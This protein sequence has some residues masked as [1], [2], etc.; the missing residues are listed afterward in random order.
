MTMTEGIYFTS[1]DPDYIFGEGVRVAPN[2]GNF[3]TDAT[4][5][6]ETDTHFLEF[7]IEP[8]NETET[9]YVIAL[10]DSL[11]PLPRATDDII[12]EGDILKKNQHFTLVSHGSNMATQSFKAMRIL[13]N[14][15]KLLVPS[16][17]ERA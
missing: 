9:E 1:P 10:V 6:V 11:P 14:I 7:S 17:D 13:S 3:P 8:K 16:M 12:V 5:H 2:E 4:V 15:E